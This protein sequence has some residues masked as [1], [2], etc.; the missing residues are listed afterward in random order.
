MIELNAQGGASVARQQ[1]A[2]EQLGLTEAFRIFEASQVLELYTG[3][4]L[5]QLPLPEGEFLV[6]MVDPAG[7]RRFGIVRFHGLHDQEQWLCG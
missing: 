4:G 3:F 5:F 6:G 7:I 1:Q 2:R